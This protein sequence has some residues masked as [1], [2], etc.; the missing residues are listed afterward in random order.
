MAQRPALSWGLTNQEILYH[1]DP[2]RAM[3]VATPEVRARANDRLRET[4]ARATR[5]LRGERGMLEALAER[6]VQERTLKA[7][8]QTEDGR[9]KTTGSLVKVSQ[10]IPV[11]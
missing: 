11:K 5:L 10:R 2:E 9:R 6:L 8:G 1:D 3:K 4:M 7:Q